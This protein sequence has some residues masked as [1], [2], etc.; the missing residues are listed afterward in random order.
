MK[1]AA[2]NAMYARYLN[3]LSASDRAQAWTDV[4]H[5]LFDQAYWIKLGDF[6]N[7]NGYRTQLHGLIGW[8]N[9]RFWGVWK[10]G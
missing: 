9:L 1:D 10:D 4:Q 8:Y 2:L 7:I 3:S 6:A 5:R